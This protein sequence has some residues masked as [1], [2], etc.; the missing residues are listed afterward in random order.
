[1]R[2]LGNSVD[3]DRERFTMDEGLS[4]AVREV[5]VRLHEQGLMYRG[6]RL[7]NWDPKL[8]TA[9]SDLEVE[10]HNKQGS[11]W[12]LRYPLADGA[13]TA[14]GKN[15]IV[16]ATTR[17]ETLLGDVAVMVHPEDARYSALVGKEIDLPLCGRRIPIIADEHVDMEFGTGCVKVTP[18][19]D[20]NDYE[21]GQRHQLPL[22]N[23]L[24]TD[25]TVRPLAQVFEHTGEVS[26]A[27]ELALPEAYHNQDRYDARKNWLQ[28]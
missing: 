12:Y 14:D 13:T 16:I 22:I 9:I 20:F 4:N 17:P 26:S 10:N 1:M 23:V 21:V 28:I 7:V 24:N 19:H 6:K 5:F 2:R 3:W 15:Y 8:H 25:A 11:M 27:T 18:A